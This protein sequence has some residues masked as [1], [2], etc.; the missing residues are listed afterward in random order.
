MPIPQNVLKKLAAQ[1]L[2]EVHERDSANAIEFGVRKFAADAGLN[3]EESNQF[4]DELRQHL[5]STGV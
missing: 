1:Q 2:N 5:N 3:E 4:V